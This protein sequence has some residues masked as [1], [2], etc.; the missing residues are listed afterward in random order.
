MTQNQVP[1][2]AFHFLQ[3]P[4][5]HTVPDKRLDHSNDVFNGLTVAQLTSN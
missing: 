3:Y 1:Q 4:L 2:F 5:Y